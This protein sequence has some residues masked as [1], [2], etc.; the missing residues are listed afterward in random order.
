MQ[1]WGNIGAVARSREGKIHLATMALVCFGLFALLLAGIAYLT[2][3]SG[4]LIAALVL[5][6]LAASAVSGL[7]PDRPIEEAPPAEDSGGEKQIAV[8]TDRV[9]EMRE[10]EERFNELIEAL[11]DLVV[12][13]DRDGRILYANGVFIDLV[14]RSL[15][16]I[17]G[18]TLPQLGIEVGLVPEAAFEDGQSIS[19]TDVSIYTPKGTHWFSWTELSSRD[20]DSD[21]V[22]HRAIARDITA[23][24][25]TETALVNARERAEQANQAKSRFLATVSH[26]IRTP[27]N[28]IMGMATLLIDTRLSAEQRTYV[29][30]ISTSGAALLALIED[31][32]DYS[33]IEAGRLELEPQRMNVRELVESI[34][35]LLASR[36]FAKHIGLGCHIAPDVPE[37]IFADPGR[38]RQVLLNLLGNAVKFTEE[39]GI[40]VTVKTAMHDG[41]P[42]LA[43]AVNDT[44]PGLD[45]DAKLR[46]FRDF[47]QADS[48]TTRRHGGAG[49]GLAISR[50]LMDAMSGTLTVDS[51]PGEGST[52]TVRLPAREAEA[53]PEGVVPALKGWEIALVT[54]HAVEGEALA[55]TIR[56]HEGQARVFDSEASAIA[57]LQRDRSSFDAVIIDATLEDDKGE[58]LSRLRHHGLR[59]RQALTLIAPNDRGRLAAFRAAGYSVFLARPAR[60][61]TLLR[62]LLNGR[63]D[64]DESSAID[65]GRTG[66]RTSGSSL[67]VLVAEDNEI[68]A[69][70]ARATLTKAGHKVTL[71]TNG[72]AAVD[73]LTDPARLYDA[74]L[75]DL[76]MPVMDG[77]DAIASIRRYEEETGRPPM[78]ILVLSADGQEKTRHGVLA[79]GASGFVTKPLD[80]DRLLAAL[81]EHASA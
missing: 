77:L 64:V 12:H 29:G 18:K 73:M 38:L 37:T 15:A 72:R 2:G 58:L 54:P 35:E 44:G 39:G 32:L 71:V 1:V 43:I 79:H 76:H 69:M 25:R 24:K 23:R 59:A 5:L 78:P 11:G 50:R 40:L 47:Q 21:A 36:A 45:E 33:K 74:V 6:G 70:L 65:S 53:P 16:E 17:K 31:L 9:G 20:A 27:M 10:S 22:S 28:G 41:Q 56:A 75:M 13:R 49:L 34:V 46:I 30:A 42:A 68:N 55:M 60:G 8:L 48:S 61:R 57:L 52:F 19:S 67:S 80:P 3:A 63:P 62:L 7:L 51:A 66:N 14:Q 81:E 4:I 26:E